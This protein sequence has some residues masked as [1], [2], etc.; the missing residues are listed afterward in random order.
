MRLTENAHCEAAQLLVERCSNAEVGCSRG[1]VNQK[2]NH[3]RRRS[4][5]SLPSLSERTWPLQ[6][7]DFEGRQAGSERL[8]REWRTVFSGLNKRRPCL[9]TNCSGSTLGPR[10]HST[11]ISD[12]NLTRLRLASSIDAPHDRPKTRCQTKSRSVL[13]ERAIPPQ[14]V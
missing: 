3:Q 8:S 4:P 11:I 9:W 6:M 1:V 5:M 10:Y 13:H 12:L 7:V 2:R 14:L